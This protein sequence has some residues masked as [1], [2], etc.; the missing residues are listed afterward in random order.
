MNEEQEAEEIIR[1]LKK[2]SFESIYEVW[3]TVSLDNPYGFLEEH[4]W[5]FEEFTKIRREKGLLW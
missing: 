2:A 1:R 5:T 3:M 4:G